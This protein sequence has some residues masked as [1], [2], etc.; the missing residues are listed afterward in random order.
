MSLSY[1]A[2]DYAKPR[3]RGGALSLTPLAPVLIGAALAVVA[4][5]ARS[6]IGAYLRGFLV[7]PRGLPPRD[8]LAARI[9]AGLS[10]RALRKSILGRRKAT[11]VTS[12]GRPRT[13]V[14]NEIRPVLP[15]QAAFW[16]ADT[17]YYAIDARTQ[18][19]M[20]IRFVDGIA[21]GVEFFG[22]PKPE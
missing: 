10:L 20:A 7:A 19:A 13:A 17:W 8:N 6:R 2:D 3:G 5:A 9:E 11:I 1:P 21:R 4:I 16:R 18:T 22:T 14:M 15:N 12:C